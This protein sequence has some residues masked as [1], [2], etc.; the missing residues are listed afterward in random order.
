LLAAVLVFMLPAAATI[1]PSV[2]RW[3]VRVRAGLFGLAVAVAFLAAAAAFVRDAELARLLKTRDVSAK[4]RRLI[5]LDATVAALLANNPALGGFEPTLYQ[6]D[7]SALVPMWP[8]PPAADF[9]R[10]DVRVFA[11][12]KGATGRAFAERSVFGVYGTDV[13]NDT[14]ELTPDQRQRFKGYRSAVAF[15]I[16]RDD[17]AE[18]IGCLT[19]LRKQ[20][21][22]RFTSDR[23]AADAVR[24]LCDV[25]GTLMSMMRPDDAG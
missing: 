19:L 16:W 23:S 13:E 25:L 15:P 17:A 3:D 6:Y 24:Q 4:Q 5:T 2:P 12:G 22:E 21:D 20:P 9:G 10:P 8:P 1:F 11:P 14:H 7:G 18:V